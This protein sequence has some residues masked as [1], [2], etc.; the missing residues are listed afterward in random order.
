MKNE[1]KFDSATSCYFWRMVNEDNRL[2]C[3]EECADTIRAIG[4]KYRI[5]D[6]VFGGG[7]GYNVVFLVDGDDNVFTIGSENGQ[8][9]TFALNIIDSNLELSLAGSAGERNKEKWTIVKYDEFIECV[10]KIMKN[11]KYSD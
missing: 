4:L 1:I 2:W 11:S 8:M 10:V 7:F 9:T 5:L 3:K 6:K